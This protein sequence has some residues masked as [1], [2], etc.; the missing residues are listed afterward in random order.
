[1]EQHKAGENVEPSRRERA[2]APS[3][4]LPRTAAFPDPCGRRFHTHS[5]AEG[6]LVSHF[7]DEKTEAQGM[8]LKSTQQERSQVEIHTVSSIVLLHSAR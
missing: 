5:P 7:R 4:G 8:L 6:E 1:M 3:P 2:S